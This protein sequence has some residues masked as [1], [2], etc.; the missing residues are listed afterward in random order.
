MSFQS[1]EWAEEST[2]PTVDIR[3]KGD[4]VIIRRPKFERDQIR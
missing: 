4:V 2:P 3:P 1:P